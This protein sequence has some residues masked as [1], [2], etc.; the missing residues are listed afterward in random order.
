MKTFLAVYTGRAPGAAADPSPEDIARGMA[1]W[2]KWMEDHADQFLDGG[3]PLGKT[4][5]VSA[6]GVKDISNLMT[7]YVTLKA[8]S[9]DAAAKLFLNHPHFAIFP[10]KSVE[11]MEVMPIPTA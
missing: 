3:G 4:K 1:A 9:H 6:A 7:G 10:G 2:G 5:E 8:E 11:I